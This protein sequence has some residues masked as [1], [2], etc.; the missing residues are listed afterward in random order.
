MTE[1]KAC[2]TRPKLPS[3]I[4]LPRFFPTAGP[5]FQEMSGKSSAVGRVTPSGVGVSRY[6][7]NVEVHLRRGQPER[8]QHVTEAVVHRYGA[9]PAQFGELSLP[10]GPSARHR[11]GLPR[12]VL[13]GPVRPVARPPARRR[14]GRARVRGLEPGVPPVRQRRRLARHL[15]GR[16]G[17]DRPARHPAGRRVPGGRHRAQRGRAPRGVGGGTTQAARPRARRAAAGAVTGVVSQA[18]CSGWRTARATGS[19]R[20]RRSS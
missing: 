6:C 11:G 10:D 8:E 20:T 16:R 19:A 7:E 13:G 14:P 2:Y 9:D 12:R 18:G 1:G 3:K 17:R 5:T 4:N 15:R